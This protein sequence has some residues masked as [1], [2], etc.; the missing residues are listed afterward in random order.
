MKL[1]EGLRGPIRYF[2]RELPRLAE[3]EV[4]S[5]GDDIFKETLSPGR[6]IFPYDHPHPW[7]C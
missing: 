6:P 2:R 7:R 3:L 4:W 5:E 1:E